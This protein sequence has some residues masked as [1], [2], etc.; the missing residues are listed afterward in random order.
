ME[1]S[2][3]HISHRQLPRPTLEEEPELWR[4]GLLALASDAVVERDFRLMLGA[5][6]RVR[7]F[8]GRVRNAQSCTVSDLA[9]M[10]PR[11]AD[12]A[13]DVA[14]ASTLHAMA[15]GCTSATPV[16][17]FPR[18]AEAIGSTR[19]GIPV[20]TPFVAAEAAL[21]ILGV[22]RISVLAPY[23]PEVSDIVIRSLERSGYE[24]VASASLGL[25]FEEEFP[26]VAGETL[27]EA[28]LT[29]DDP[30]TE[31]IFISCTAV[32][33]AEIVAKLEAATGKP[34]ISGNQALLWHALRLAGCPF[35]AGGYGRIFE[36]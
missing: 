30:R 8:C 36:L 13:A 21:R 11:I 17:G 16:I 1:Q 31:A 24:I 22:Q 5:E 12:A 6:D 29:V 27:L 34:V 14:S 15:F 18:I 20:T 9:G 10:L 7:V 4:I 28:A 19:P 3:F 23:I 25:A 33:A 32:R 2:A 26:R 35:Q